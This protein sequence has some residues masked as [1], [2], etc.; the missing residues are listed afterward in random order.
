MCEGHHSLDCTLS[1]LC[2]FLLLSLSSHASLPKWRICWMGPIKVHN[3][4]MVGILCDDTMSGRPKIRTVEKISGNLILAGWHL[5]KR[6]IILASSL[7]PAHLSPP[8]LS[9]RPWK[10]FLEIL[11]TSDG[12]SFLVKLQKKEALTKAFFWEFCEISKNTFL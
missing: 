10:M 5:Y 3:I 1:V 12:V 7:P 9:I 4:A 11:Q 2:H 6:D 8:L